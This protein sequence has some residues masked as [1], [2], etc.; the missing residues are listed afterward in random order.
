VS[1]AEPRQQQSRLVALVLGL[2]AAVLVAAGA[3]VVTR[4]L[5]SEPAPDPAGPVTPAPG[6]SSAPE[7]GPPPEGCRTGSPILTGQEEVRELCRRYAGRLRT[8]TDAMYA[9]RID[10]R[11]EDCRAEADAAWATLTALAGDPAFD[12]ARPLVEGA[13]ELAD[14]AGRH[15]RSKECRGRNT[16]RHPT[17]SACVSSYSTY[18]V[19]LSALE[20]RLRSL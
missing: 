14:E 12:D 2:F 11:I 19:G 16:L 15:Y 6:T 4:Q 5:L 9:C 20:H 13:F 3:I 10:A 18:G 17:A 1:D 8:G 7:P